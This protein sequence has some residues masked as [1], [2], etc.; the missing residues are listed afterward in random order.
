M[1][2]PQVNIRIT[3]TGDTSGAQAVGR[4]LDALEQEAR[5]LTQQMR[6]LATDSDAFNETR[7]R[8]NGLNEEIRQLKTGKD[9]VARSAASFGQ[10]ML[11]GSRGIQ[12]FSAAGIPGVVNNLE[13]LATALGMTA[14]AA[15]GITL[16]A[17]GLDLLVK[18]WD[19]IKGAFGSAD[20]VKA[21]WTA[22]TPEEAALERLRLFNEA[23]EN[24]AIKLERIRD[25][26]VGAIEASRQEDEM[27]Q[28][29]AKLWEDIVPE[30]EPGLPALP[31]Q[32]AASPEMREAQRKAAEASAKTQA[33][34]GQ[35]N[36]LD[37]AVIEQQKRLEIMQQIASFDQ[38]LKLANA[39]DEEEL[40]KVEARIAMAGQ[41]GMAP[42][43]ALLNERAAIQE[44]M[45]QRR[46][47]MRSE[48][49]N[50]PGLTDGLTGDPQRDQETLQKRA[51]EERARLQDLER[52]RLAAAQA[53]EQAA[54]E[55]A[56]AEQGVTQQASF[57]TEQ[58]AAASF[59]ET[60]MQPLPGQFAGADAAM[61]IAPAIQQQNEAVKVAM[62][63]TVQVV[64]S[65]GATI[66]QGLSDV[67]RGLAANLSAMVREVAALKATI[68]G[69]A[70]EIENLRA[71][72][73]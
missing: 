62:D 51:A 24:Q 54:R 42:P 28:K 4:S 13:G 57:Q 35:F 47:Q 41:G 31:G 2:E 53:A 21:L 66:Q 19:K 18:N 56:L 3:T 15:G 23:L 58:A 5:Q 16:V 46:E 71:S 50:V 49:G 61:G 59:K 45:T 17:V 63:Q 48:I 52:Q 60:G 55:Q 67:N 73:R 26:R 32:E 37:A 11:Q 38:R 14:G 36:N 22:L 29:K 10:A 44:R 20:Q 65:N 1:A 69:Q 12:D 6:Q 7:T 34:V 30:Q 33:A 70:A 40:K 68:Q 9:G 27:L 8:L 72:N 64:Q 39:G 25:A 43:A